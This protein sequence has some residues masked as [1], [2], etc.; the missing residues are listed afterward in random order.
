[1]SEF[2]T[3]STMSLMT[4]L[5][6]GVIF[7]LMNLPVPAPNTLIGVAGVVGL[8]IGYMLYMKLF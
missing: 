7:A 8:T 2:L 1:M 3:Q 4:G 5:V 6:T